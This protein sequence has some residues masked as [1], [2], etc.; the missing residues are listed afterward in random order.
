MRIR[1]LNAL[2]VVFL[3]SLACQNNNL[4][5]NQE[6]DDSGETGETGGPRSFRLEQISPNPF[7]GSAL[8]K[9]TVDK[10]LFVNLRISGNNT[11]IQVL[12]EVR[13]AGVHY[14]VFAPPATMASGDYRCILEQ[15]GEGDVDILI[16][17]FRR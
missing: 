16:M 13:E 3:L 14:V 6:R 5:G 10:D 17:K 2:M 4:T 9:F 7:S 8:I 11:I 12:N 1:V 15:V